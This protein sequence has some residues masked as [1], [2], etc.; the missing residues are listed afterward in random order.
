MTTRSSTISTTQPTRRSESDGRATPR[1]LAREYQLAFVGSVWALHWVFVTLFAALAT[2]YAYS[3]PPVKAVGYQLPALEG[4]QH[5]V[6]QPMRNWDGFWYSLI[7]DR[8]YDYHPAS[9]AFWPLYPWTM[10]LVSNL[11]VI[12][13]EVAGYVLANIAFL[14]ALVFFHR[15]VGREWGDG[16][17]RRATVLLAFFPTAFYFNAVYSESFFLLFTV[18]A[19]YSAKCGKWWLALAAAVLA[20]LTRNLG[21]LLLIPLTIIF[22]KQHWHI[23]R[24]HWKKPTRWP[25]EALALALVPLGPALYLLYLWVDFGDPLLTLEAQKG[26]A[27]EQ[28]MPWTAFAMAFEQWGLGWLRELLAS[29]TWATLTSFEVRRSFAEYESLDIIF[30]FLGLGFLAYA[31][32]RLPLEYWA[33]SVVLFALPLF[34]PSTIHPLMSVPRFLVVLFPIFIG[35]ALLTERRWLFPVILIPSATVMAALVVQFST[36]FW[37]S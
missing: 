5:Y 19:F 13:V 4:W 30:A 33:Y 7:A 11:L 1:R 31:V 20:G 23:L 37:V 10:K 17:A 12:R 26:W 29:P 6:I 36:W 3:Q 2:H 18:L 28:G 9:T 14:A 25:A 27:R 22:V 34:S 32:R 35:L 21:V 24:W 15:L 16:V 8:G